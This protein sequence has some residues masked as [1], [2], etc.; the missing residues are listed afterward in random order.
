MAPDTTTDRV[1]AALNEIRQRSERPV[2][3]VGSLP[4]THPGVRGLM[5]S[6]GDVPCLL[7][8]LDRVLALHHKSTIYAL[9][10]SAHDTQE[11]PRVWCGH[12]YEET[13]NGRHVIADNDSVLCLDKPEGDVCAEC[14]EEGGDEAVEWPCPTYRAISAALLGEPAPAGEEAAGHG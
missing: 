12:T 13:E 5:E 3:R 14:W 9:S 6:A 4:I 8:A 11:P 2:A 1:T 7:A 10:V